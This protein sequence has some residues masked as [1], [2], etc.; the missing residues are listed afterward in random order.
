MSLNKSLAP[1][2]R[3][4]ETK[5]MNFR[6]S[7]FRETAGLIENLRL[8]F[9]IFVFNEKILKLKFQYTNVKFVAKEG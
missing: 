5:K 7:P 1:S 3:P 9:E 4:A 8:K 2:N 6:A